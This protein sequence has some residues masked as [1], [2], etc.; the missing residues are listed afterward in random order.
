MARK[1]GKADEVVSEV[2]GDDPAAELQ[3]PPTEVLYAAE[4]AK[5]AEA[6]AGQSR[7]C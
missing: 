3:R 7:P 1:R 5:L 6:D 2:V 4:L